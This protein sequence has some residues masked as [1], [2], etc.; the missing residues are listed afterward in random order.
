M[1]IA[2]YA[3]T[4]YI[5]RALFGEDVGMTAAEP[6]IG[7]WFA[8]SPILPNGDGRPVVIGETLRVKPPLKLCKRGLHGSL[9]PFDA[10]HYAP[11][12]FLYR[13]RYSGEIIFGDDKLCATERTAL[14]MVDATELLRIFAR[15]QALTVLHLWDAPSIVKTYLETGDENI[16]DAARSAAWAVVRAAALD[17]PRQCC[18]EH[19]TAARAAARAAAHAATRVV[20]WAATQAAL[21]V[22]GAQGARDAFFELVNSVMV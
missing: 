15:Q 12:T 3:S 6:V 18:D 21:G 11:G 2:R 20:T 22:L 17:A 19:A 8:A 1:I 9:H 4:T 7:Y 5:E 10:L 14:A 13:C 16:M